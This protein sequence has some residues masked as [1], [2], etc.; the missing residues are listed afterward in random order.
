MAG[1]CVSKPGWGMSG[2][3]VRSDLYGLCAFG[4]FSVAYIITLMF[5]G[6][7]PMRTRGSS[8]TF[9]SVDVF[10]ALGLAVSSAWA[11][12]GVARPPGPGSQHYRAY[13]TCGPYERYVDGLAGKGY[14]YEEYLQRQDEVSGL[15][16]GCRGAMTAYSVGFILAVAYMITATLMLLRI[17][18]RITARTTLPPELSTEGQRMAFPELDSSANRTELDR[19][20]KG[21]ELDPAPFRAELDPATK[22]AELEGDTRC[23]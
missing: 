3:I 17:R 2:H 10:V 16:G 6:G 22:K 1:L 23:N 14:S 4:Y 7:Y 18:R 15:Q 9:L 20:E 19:N 11:A 8:V 21:A 12:A 5:S 13:S